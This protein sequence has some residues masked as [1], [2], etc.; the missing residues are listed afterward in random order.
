M[1]N[2]VPPPCWYSKG[3]TGAQM[4]ADSN[5]PYYYGLAHH[6]GENHDDWFPPQ[7]ADHKDDDGN[8]YSWECDS[9]QLRR[10]DHRTSSSTSTQWTAQNPDLVWVAGRRSSRRSRRCRRRSSMEIARDVRCD[11]LVRMPIVNFNPAA[12][13]ASSGCRPGCGSTRRPGSRSR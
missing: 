1:P 10:V 12:S 3:R 4:S 9:G 5:D 11:E 8:W 6:V 2:A 13:V 7:V